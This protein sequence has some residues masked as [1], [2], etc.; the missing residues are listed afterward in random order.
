VNKDFKALKRQ[1]QAILPLIPEMPE[2]LSILNLDPEADPSSEMASEEESSG[3]DP[4]L[5]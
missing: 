2:N 1:S 5:L 3:E 4:L